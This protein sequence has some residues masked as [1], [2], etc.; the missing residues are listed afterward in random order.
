M[1]L[2]LLIPLVSIVLFSH[3]TGETNSSSFD[4]ETSIRNTFVSSF[5]P[6]PTVDLTLENG[7]RELKIK[8][9]NVYR[10]KK[11]DYVLT[12]DKT[13]GIDGAKGNTDLNGDNT[14]ERNITLG[15]CTSG[16]TC[17][18]HTGV[19]NFLLKVRLTDA[20]GNFTNLEKSL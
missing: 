14:W 11:I 9:T 4:L 20:D 3:L 5:I 17:T 6:D 12:Y 10:F 13:G 8:L 2:I 1:R 16:G 18:Y 7:G 15:T 19:K